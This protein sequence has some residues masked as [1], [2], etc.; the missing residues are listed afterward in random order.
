MARLGAA[1]ISIY[2]FGLNLNPFVT[3]PGVRA[4]ALRP[5]GL[6]P[7]TESFSSVSAVHQLTKPAGGV[8]Q[9]AAIVG[10]CAAVSGVED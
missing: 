1:G 10:A 5:E 6:L 9:A 2:P 3:L 4:T 8:R 7:P